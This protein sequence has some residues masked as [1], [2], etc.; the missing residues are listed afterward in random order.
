MK[1]HLLALWITCCSIAVQAQG[2]TFTTTDTAMQQACNWAFQMVQHY[3]GNPAD[4]VGPWYEAALPSRNAFCMRDV[5]H[6]TIGA[7]ICGLDKENRNMLTA[8]ARNIAASRDWCSFW[9]INKYGKPAPEDYRNDK[10]FWYNLNANFDIIFACWKLYTWTGDKRYIEEPVFVNFFEKTIHEY[11]HQWNLQADSLLTRPLHPNAPAPFNKADYF[12]RC[13][14]LASY[15]ENVPDLKAGVD[16]IATI[17]RG[18][19]S[20]SSI[21]SLRGNTAKAALYKQMAEQYREKIDQYWW[22]EKASRYYTWYNGAG[23]FGTGEGEMFLLWFDALKDTA[24]SRQ[25]ITHLISTPWNVETTSYLPVIL[26]KQGYWQKATDYIL[27]L[28]DKA[29]PRREYPEVSFGVVEGIVSGLMGI[30]PDAPSQRITTLYRGATGN[31]TTLDGLHILNT[32]IMVNHADKR[33]IFHNKGKQPLLWRAAFAGNYDK[34]ILHQTARRASHRKD[35][36]GNM[37]SYT[38]VKVRAGEKVKAEVN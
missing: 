5:A 31:N 10:E 7:A 21:L 14:G 32:T 2:P 12:H 3:R 13:R 29:T 4:P 15:V 30:E 24:R 33:T 9:E 8:F 18:L 20:Y 26:Y 35:N 1:N 38:D 19:L 27:Q 11:I 23:Q 37:I 28:T 16:L 22:N 25:T 17:Y 36:S 6:Q 34:I